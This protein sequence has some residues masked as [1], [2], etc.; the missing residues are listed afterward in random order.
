MASSTRRLLFP[1][2]PS[3][4]TPAAPYEGDLP[5]RD[6]DQPPQGK[7]PIPYRLEIAG[8][9]IGTALV[10]FVLFAL[11]VRY[12]QKSSGDSGSSTGNQDAPILFDIQE[13]FIDEDQGPQLDHPIWHIR[14][15]GLDR[16]IID[17]IMVF[18][19]RASEGLIDGRE[20]SVCLNEFRDDENLKLLPKC[21]HAFHVPCIDTW[22]HSHKNCP[23]CR[24]PIVR[25]GSTEQASPE[26][27]TSVDS[28]PIRLAEEENLHTHGISESSNGLSPSQIGEAGASENGTEDSNFGLS[29]VEDGGKIVAFSDLGRVASDLGDHRQVKGEEIQA[30]R[31]S[32]S[33][34]YP[35]ASENYHAV[36]IAM[37]DQSWGTLRRQASKKNSS[38]LSS[39]KIRSNGSGSSSLY[40]MV[41]S[42]SHGASLREEP[43]PMRRSFSSSGNVQSL[44]R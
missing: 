37:C 15:I 24:A 22:L 4:P 7:N 2:P 23:V 41:R 11:I 5:H 19:Y 3:L 8:A 21:S 43:A 35:S 34:D 39:N 6:D 29:Q 31:R 16:S 18:K 42:C 26:L 28:S 1:S 40:R 25:T 38:G 32:I 13:D 20:C 30:T 27:P 44:G 9:V 14:T 17:S 10:F 33:V 12:F 36:A